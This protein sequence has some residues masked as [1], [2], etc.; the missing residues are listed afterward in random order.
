M[1][2]GWIGVDLD[3]TLAHH[4]EGTGAPIPGEPIGPM[5]ERV[6]R[7]L[8]AGHDVRIFTA[9]GQDQITGGMS[10]T[11]GLSWP[12]SNWLQRSFIEQWCLRHLGQVLLI[13]NC[14]DL[15]LWCLFD[16]R[17]VHVFPNAGELAPSGIPEELRDPP[18]PPCRLTSWVSWCPCHGWCL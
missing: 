15:H 9:R 11:E 1:S 12:E 10:P 7:W 6:K 13:T 4:A 5:V 2:K 3:R 14:K 17:A 16:D 18:G 8:A